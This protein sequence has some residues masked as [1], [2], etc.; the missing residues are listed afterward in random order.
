[1]F[2]CD[3]VQEKP[4]ARFTC[5]TGRLSLPQR[6]YLLASFFGSAGRNAY[7]VGAA[8]LLIDANGQAGSIAIFLTLGCIVE[9]LSAL[10]AGTLADR[11]DRRILCVFC[12]I[13]RSLIMLCI[14]AALL[15]APSH[16]VLLISVALYSVADRIYLTASPAIIPSLAH[17][18]SLLRLNA[19]SYVGMQAGNVVAATAAGLLLNVSPGIICFLFAAM[20][21]VL[22]SISMAAVG[23]PDCLSTRPLPSQPQGAVHE[24][25]LEQDGRRLPVTLIVAYALTYTMGMLISVLA[26]AFVSQELDGNA[27]HFGLL[28]AGWALGAIIGAVLLTLRGLNRADE[29][30]I[31]WI[32][33]FLGVLLA[34]LFLTRSI[35]ACIL[36]ISL[37]GAGYNVARVL[38][39][40]EIQYLVR[41]TGLG[42]AKGELHLA[43]T[44]LSL[45]LYLA[46]ATSGTLLPSTIFLA[47]GAVMIICA[48]GIYVISARQRSCARLS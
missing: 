41:S 28:E 30:A 17:A 13:A 19:L 24:P 43:C 15:F 11:I 29:Q 45:L 25:A 3:E 27:M 38:V 37:L 21:F 44:G 47:Y 1:M 34:V 12:D 5:K 35:G 26:S 7:Y 42:R 23:K 16:S 4:A 10:P 46:L 36:L 8:W 22:S 20:A 33:M 39:E 14:S 48:V 18:D 31:R 9:F 32:V 40:A 2:G 6:H